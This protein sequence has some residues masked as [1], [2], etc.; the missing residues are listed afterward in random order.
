VVH[1]IRVALCK[2]VAILYKLVTDSLQRSVGIIPNSDIC[3]LSQLLYISV[4][5]K[6]DIALIFYD[7][8]IVCVRK[9]VDCLLKL[10]VVIGACL[11]PQ[12]FAGNGILSHDYNIRFYSA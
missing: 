5:L 7:L 9:N 4:L 3:I 1:N 8:L 11:Y 6:I 2:F 10:F 12:S